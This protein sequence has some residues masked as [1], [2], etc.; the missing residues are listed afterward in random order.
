[1]GFKP[2]LDDQLV[3]FSALTLGLVI[4]PAKIVPEMTYNVL[5]GTLSLYTTIQ[6]MTNSPGRGQALRL[7]VDQLTKPTVDKPMSRPTFSSSS[8]DEKPSPY[9]VFAFA[10]DHCPNFCEVLVNI[11]LDISVL[12]TRTYDINHQHVKSWLHVTVVFITSRHV[13]KA[14]CSSNLLSS[15]ACH[16]S[17]TTN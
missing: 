13:N 9:T 5:S 2:D 12:L 17:M 4:W 8:S 1:M 16:A 6:I 3:S 10:S 14:H 7:S 11:M 15:T